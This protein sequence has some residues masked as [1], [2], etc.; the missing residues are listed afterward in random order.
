LRRID[1]EKNSIQ[2]AKTQAVTELT[3]QLERVRAEY[4]A[5]RHKLLNNVRKP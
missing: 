5:L 1:N 3:R 2:Q 4:N